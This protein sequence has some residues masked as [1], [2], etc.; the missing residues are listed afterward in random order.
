MFC[1]DLDERFWD[2]FQIFFHVRVPCEILDL[3]GSS[4]ESALD[5]LLNNVV[6]VDYP[7]RFNSFLVMGCPID[8]DSRKNSAPTLLYSV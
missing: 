6:N 3:V 7:D 1:Q 5:R 4:T 2:S 8:N